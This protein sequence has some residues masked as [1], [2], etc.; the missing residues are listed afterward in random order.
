[1][2][3]YEKIYDLKKNLNKEKSVIDIKKIQSEIL[4]DKDLVQSIKN[5]NYDRNNSLIRKYCHLE[6]EVNYIVLEINM[7]LKTILGSDCSENNTR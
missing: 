1:M 7:N 4:L 3:L 5:H 2:K 6:N